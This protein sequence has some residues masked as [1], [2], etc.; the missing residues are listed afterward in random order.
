MPLDQQD[1]VKRM[2]RPELTVRGND[3]HWIFSRQPTRL[4][5][6]MRRRTLCALRAPHKAR[7]QTRLVRRNVRLSAETYSERGDR[8]SIDPFNGKR[9]AFAGLACTQHVR[10]EGDEDNITPRNQFVGLEGAFGTV[11]V[12]AT[13]PGFSTART[14]ARTTSVR[15]CPPLASHST[16]P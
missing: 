9:D 4:R 12:G 5:L 13:S 16:S 2:K 7:E 6:S 11:K 14:G 1:C 3:G 8:P 15:F 10:T